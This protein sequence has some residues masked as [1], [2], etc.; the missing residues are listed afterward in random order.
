MLDK[1]HT[2]Q[3]IES[4]Y[5]KNGKNFEM[6]LDQFLSN[7]IPKDEYKIVRIEQ[8]SSTE[9]IDTSSHAQ[10]KKKENSELLKQYM[11]GQFEGSNARRNKNKTYYEQHMKALELQKE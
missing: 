1:K 10:S 6:T 5:L 8:P 3:F 4:L 9:L 2:K 7:N 11:L